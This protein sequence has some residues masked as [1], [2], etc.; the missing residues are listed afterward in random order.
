MVT[1]TIDKQAAVI[2]RWKADNGISGRGFVALN[3]GSRRTPEKREL[4][5]ALAETVQE[6]DKQSQSR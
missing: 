3:N 2:E 6:Q 4:L 1:T 5:R